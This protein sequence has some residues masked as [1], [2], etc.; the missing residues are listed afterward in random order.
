MFWKLKLTNILYV[1]SFN[2]SSNIFILIL[3]INPAESTQF[4]CSFLYTV[5]GEKQQL[6]TLTLFALQI[7]KQLSKLNYF[8][9]YSL[10]LLFAFV[11]CK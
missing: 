7:F 10:W 6:Q 2:D 5:W 8:M 4:C 3:M 9:H 1:F 11:G